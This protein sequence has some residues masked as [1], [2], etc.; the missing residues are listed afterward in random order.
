MK[1]DTLD[2]YEKA[3]RSFEIKYLVFGYVIDG[4]GQMEYVSVS[5]VNEEAKNRN[6][7]KLISARVFE[8][9]EIIF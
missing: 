4:K 3:F 1:Q 5:C 9:K 7:E 6:V 2:L 8:L